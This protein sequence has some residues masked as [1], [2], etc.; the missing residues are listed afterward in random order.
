MVV[1]K[2]IESKEKW[3]SMYEG[4]SELDIDQ[5]FKAYLWLLI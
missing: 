4:I 3:R 2:S 1:S 5:N